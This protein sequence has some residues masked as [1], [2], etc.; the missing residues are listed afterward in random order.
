M[1][2]EYNTMAFLESKLSGPGIR[3]VTPEE[4][5]KR[6]DTAQA[7]PNASLAPFS[8]TRPPDASDCGSPPGHRR[9]KERDDPA[10]TAAKA[11]RVWRR[12]VY[13]L[14]SIP[15]R[16]SQIASLSTV[17]PRRRAVQKTIWVLRKSP[18]HILPT[19]FDHFAAKGTVVSI[20][21]PRQRS[22]AQQKALGPDGRRA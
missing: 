14:R 17:P 1:P 5:E 6:P 4:T 11:G 7:M 2:F 13:P 20:E 21:R 8:A 19:T 3:V 22:C 10:A 16:G 12:A 18:T 9:G 15:G